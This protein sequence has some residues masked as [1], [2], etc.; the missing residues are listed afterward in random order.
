MKTIFTF[1]GTTKQGYQIVGAGICSEE[2]SDDIGEAFE[3]INGIDMKINDTNNPYLI[4]KVLFESI[5]SISPENVLAIGASFHVPEVTERTGGILGNPSLEMDSADGLGEN[6]GNG[7]SVAAYPGGP[8]IIIEG[9]CHLAKE[10]ISMVNPEQ[11]GNLV[12]KI[13]IDA[14]QEKNVELAIIVIDGSGSVEAGCVAIY[15]KGE[16]TYLNINI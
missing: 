6:I 5:M 3:N 4:D 9:D 16:I 13:L 2:N 12:V 1:K 8:G 10:I 15:K 7:L 11:R 14:F